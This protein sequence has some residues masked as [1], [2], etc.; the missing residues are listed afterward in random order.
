MED[1]YAEIDV[2]VNDVDE[3]D[4]LGGPEPSLEERSSRRRPA[5]TAPS[6]AASVRK[7]AIE[8]VEDPYLLPAVDAPVAQTQPMAAY[9]N[10]AQGGYMEVDDGE[11][12]YMRPTA[13]K[14]MSTGYGAGRTLDLYLQPGMSLRVL[15]W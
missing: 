11:D 8:Q 2:D 10:E 15:P 6:A 13:A 7:V 12:L 5:A 3:D 1:P 9:S 14:H 4:G